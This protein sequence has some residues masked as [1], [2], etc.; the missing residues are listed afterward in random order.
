MKEPPIPLLL[1]VRFNILA[2]CTDI[3]HHGTLKRE[4]TAIS[5][6]RSHSTRELDLRDEGLLHDHYI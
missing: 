5:T 2:H 3:Y 4:I 1:K 6:C